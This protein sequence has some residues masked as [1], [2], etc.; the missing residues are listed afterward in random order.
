MIDYAEKCMKS[1]AVFAAERVS[2]INDNMLSPHYHEFYELYYLE[3]GQRYHLINNNMYLIEGGQ[4]LLFEPYMCHHSYGDKDVPFCRLV[5]YFREDEIISNEL[6][7]ILKGSSG[8]YKLQKDETTQF[9]QLMNMIHAEKQNPQQYSN[10]YC[11]SLLNT[12]LIILFRNKRQKMRLVQKNQITDIIS[13]INANYMNDLSITDIA[14]HFYIS[15]F[16]LCREFK[17]HTNST[18]VQYINKTRIMN[19][20]RLLYSSDDNITNISMNTGFSNV[21]HFGRVFKDITG[22]TPSSW[23]KQNNFFSKNKTY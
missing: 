18:I 2:G 3:S 21:S 6:K 10:E 5:I 8:A 23:R 17:K 15:T 9:Y 19:A 1:G 20:Q 11:Q 7:Q 12:M 4:F 14:G 22:F 16:Y 13:Y